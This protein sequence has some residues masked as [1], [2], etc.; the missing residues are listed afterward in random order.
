MMHSTA[1]GID[2]QPSSGKSSL[3][4]IQHHAA[5]VYGGVEAELHAHLL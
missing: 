3:Y 4:L 1:D 2:T 5:K